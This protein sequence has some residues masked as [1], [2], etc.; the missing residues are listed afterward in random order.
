MSH[1]LLIKVQGGLVDEYVV[2]SAGNEQNLW[3][4]G[5]KKKSLDCVQV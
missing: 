4:V 3:R 1:I 2:P 5:E